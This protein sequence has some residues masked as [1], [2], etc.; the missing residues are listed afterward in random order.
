MEPEGWQRAQVIGRFNGSAMT[1]QAHPEIVEVRP[2]GAEH[3]VVTV[4]GGRGKHRR[5]PCPDCP[6]RTDATG[7]FPAEAFRHSAPTAYDMSDRIFSC[8]QSG[9]KKPATCAGFLLRGADHNLAVRLGKIQGKY[10]KVSDGGH[11]LHASYRAMAIA[12]GIPSDDPVL[13]GCR[14]D[15]N[16]RQ[17]TS[18]HGGV[19]SVRV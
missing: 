3:Q 11:E 8:H 2:A 6:W 17:A 15:Q 14:D 1:R 13:A 4:K 10:A 18:V 12:N 7:K 19:K 9:S 16:T 5:E